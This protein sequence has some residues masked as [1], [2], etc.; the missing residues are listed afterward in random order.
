MTGPDFVV[1]TD[2]DG[3]LLDHA[4]YDWGPALPALSQLRALSIP[5][6]LSS[7]KTAAEIAPIRAKLRLSSYPAIVENGAGTLAPNAQPTDAGEDY[8]R[9]RA[10]LD[11]LPPRLRNCFHGF[12]DWDDEEVI[13]QTGL[14]PDAAK[15]ARQRAF[16][17]PGLWS[18]SRAD[19]EAFIAALGAHGISARRGGRFLTLS[20][21]G[22]KADRMAEVLDSLRPKDGPAPMSVALGDA[23]NDVEMLNAATVGIIIANPNA[24]EL[25]VLAGERDGHIRRSTKSGPSGWN[26]MMLALVSELSQDERAPD[27]GEQGDTSQGLH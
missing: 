8:A 10:A 21:G 13:I 22:T 14:A 12:G 5:V 17:E 27:G 18:G 24:Q 9:L 11:A 19:R 6:V 3:T 25:P 20:F 7:S 26:E 16:S 15:Q 2:L 23:P 4:T 1:F